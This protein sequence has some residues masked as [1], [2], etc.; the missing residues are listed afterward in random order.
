MLVSKF[1]IDITDTPPSRFKCIMPLFQIINFDYGMKEKN[2]W[3]HIH[4]YSKDNPQKVE[5]LSPEKVNVKTVKICSKI[6]L[7]YSTIYL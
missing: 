2:P 6:H 3:D 7:P 1:P 5:T 4:F